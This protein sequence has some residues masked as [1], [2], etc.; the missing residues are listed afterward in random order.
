MIVALLSDLSAEVIF[1]PRS[2]NTILFSLSYGVALSA[3]LYI[4]VDDATV[5]IGQL[6]LQPVSFQYGTKDTTLIHL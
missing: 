2:A 6:F 4:A 1:L 5:S 3:I